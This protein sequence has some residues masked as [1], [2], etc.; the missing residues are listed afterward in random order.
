MYL[1]DDEQNARKY[2]GQEVRLVGSLNANGNGVNV[3]S[4]QSI[5]EK[6]PT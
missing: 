6:P 1:L 4:I 3:L 2:D 5:S